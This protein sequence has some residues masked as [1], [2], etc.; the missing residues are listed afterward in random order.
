MHPVL[1]WHPVGA[2]QAVGLR[3]GRVSVSDER[4]RRA[5]TCCSIADHVPSR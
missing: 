4:L 5:V 2:S 3:A 1:G